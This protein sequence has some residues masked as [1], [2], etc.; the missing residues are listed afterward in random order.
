MG[1]LENCCRCGELAQLDVFKTCSKCGKKR[2]E[3]LNEARPLAVKN[4]D[5][6]Y[7]EIA[8][9]IGAD[10]EEVLALVWGG[11]L[12]CGVAKWECQQCGKKN[13][14]CWI[15]QQCGREAGED[16]VTPEQ[17]E[18]LEGSRMALPRPSER[19]VRVK[20]RTSR[21]NIKLLKLGM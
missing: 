21:N 11:F 12:R 17:K 7:Q 8:N 15:C 10:E 14:N 5:L 13:K 2:Q 4:P 6:T 18:F 19:S 16:Q 3:L 20:E 1:K 9:K